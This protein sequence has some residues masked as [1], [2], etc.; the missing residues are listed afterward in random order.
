[1]ELT[2]LCNFLSFFIKIIFNSPGQLKRH[3]SHEDNEA[4]EI[5]VQV[6]RQIDYERS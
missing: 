5:K 1:M 6:M 4:T 3:I 2:L